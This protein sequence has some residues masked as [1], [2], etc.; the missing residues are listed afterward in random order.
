MKPRPSAILDTVLDGIL[1]T[2]LLF[3][4]FLLFAGHNAPGGGFVGGLT[5]GAAILLLYVAGGIAE[6]DRH[7]PVREGVF[8]GG[9]VLLATLTGLGGHLWGDAFL[10]SAKIETEVGILGTF[11]ATTAL[12]FDIGV[13]LVVVGLTLAILR[14]LGTEADV[15]DGEPVAI[16]PVHAPADHTDRGDDA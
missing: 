1:R 2:S 13:Y 15:G 7:V 6:V 3:S 9:G 10:A 11:K 4:L 5:A 12:P 16:G 8:L 14:A